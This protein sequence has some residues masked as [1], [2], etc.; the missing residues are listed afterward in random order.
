[1]KLLVLRD[2]KPGHFHQAEGVALAVARLAPAEIARLDIRPS[3]F[4]HDDIRKIIMRKW[5]R[6]PGWWLKAMYHI[7]VA[8]LERPDVLIG[9]GRPTVAAGILLKR[10]FGVPFLYSG[11]I[12]GYDTREV[13]LQVVASPRSGGN[14][15]SAY[16]LIPST[17][18]PDAYPPPRRLATVADLAGAEIALMIGGTAYRK[19]WPA[20]EWQALARLVAEVA[21]RYGV[22][23]RV[24]TSRRTPDEVVDMFAGLNAQGHLAEF[25]DYRA[26]GAGSA[27]DMFGADAVVVTEDSMSMLA[28][29]LTARRPVIGLRSAV[30]HDAYA[31]EAIAGM[32][33]GPSLAILPLAS[34]TA[35]QFAAT[36]TRLVPPE[37]D[38]RARLTAAVASV[39]GLTP[40]AG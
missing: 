17:V 38:P 8:A 1:M 4:A 40:P 16:A 35:E 31:N 28:E 2:K 11:Q 6:D 39:L 23:W 13:D 25:I 33:S 29:G 21:A 26:A 32:A 3:W 24:S 9:S 37:G 10:V 22:R 18:D 14:P 7:D 27:R 15:R 5:G 19:T 30:V 12:G 36:L 34:V 20:N